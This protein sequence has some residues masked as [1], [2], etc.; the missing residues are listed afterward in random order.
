MELLFQSLPT[1][2]KHVKTQQTP[3]MS[4]RHLQRKVLWK[5]RRLMQPTS[6]L[7][8]FEAK[9]TS[10]QSKKKA[11]YSSCQSLSDWLAAKLVAVVNNTVSRE[12]RKD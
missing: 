12:V 3:S 9:V 6:M 2:V 8:G 5:L 7:P 11:F 1:S 10:L 4:R